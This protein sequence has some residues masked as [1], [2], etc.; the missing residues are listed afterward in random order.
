MYDI[1]HRT[2]AIQSRSEIEPDPIC[3]MTFE[4]HLIHLSNLEFC[5]TLGLTLSKVNP[6]TR[7]KASPDIKDSNTTPLSEKRERKRAR[8]MSPETHGINGGRPAEGP[9]QFSDPIEVFRKAFPDTDPDITPLSKSTES[10]RVEN[11]SPEPYGT[12][13]SRSANGTFRFNDPI[14]VFRK[15]F[16][17]IDPSSESEYDI[18]FRPFANRS[19]F[20]P[21]GDPSPRQ[22]GSN[23]SNRG[24]YQPRVDSASEVD[25]EDN[26]QYKAFGSNRSR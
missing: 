18:D 2:L 26:D 16:P 25:C 15:A 5:E 9:F 13:D 1:R 12:N 4:Q 11:R 7:Q 24:R 21:S 17:D 20:D 23:R 3:S 6:S 19:P 8:N 22:N 10:K 14:E